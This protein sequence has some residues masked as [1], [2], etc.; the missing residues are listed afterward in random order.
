MVQAFI[1]RLPGGG[2]GIRLPTEAEWEYAARAKTTTPFNLGEN[3]DTTRVN[4]NGNY[5]YNGAKKGEYRQQT[6]ASGSLANK[7]AFGLSDMHGNVWEWTEDRYGAYDLSK[8]PL[9]DPKGS[10]DGPYRVI[11][12]GR[13]GSGAGGTRVANRADWGPDDGNIN[14]GVRLLRM[15]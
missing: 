12:G 5:P 15:P 4:Y 10:V 7:N 14:V 13:W 11:R 1:K 2:A 3:I 9:V 6:V 8:S